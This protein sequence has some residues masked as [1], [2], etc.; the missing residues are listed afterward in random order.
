MAPTTRSRKSSAPFL[1]EDTKPATSSYHLQD[2][3]AGHRADLEKIWASDNRTP[4]LVSR[5]AW[6]EARSVDPSYVNSWFTRKKAQVLRKGLSVSPGSY[7]LAVCAPSA[8]VSSRKRNPNPRAVKRER[9]RSPLPSD[10]LKKRRKRASSPTGQRIK[11]ASPSKSTYNHSCLVRHTRAHEANPHPAC[12]TCF[13]MQHIITASTPA[14]AKPF[15]YFSFPSSPASSP[16][17][18]FS[19]EAPSSDFDIDIPLTPR[20]TQR[21][22][23][24]SI[25][26]S[27][28]PSGHSSDVRYCIYQN[29]CSS[30]AQVRNMSA[31][32]PVESPVHINSTTSMVHTVSVNSQSLLDDMIDS[33]PVLPPRQKR[34][35]MLSTTGTYRASCHDTGSIVLSVAAASSLPEGLFRDSTTEFCNNKQ[36]LNSPKNVVSSSVMLHFAPQ[37]AE[38]KNHPMASRPASSGS[39]TRNTREHEFQQE[40]ASPCN[41]VPHRPTTFSAGHP[42]VGTRN[43]LALSVDNVV[44]HNVENLVPKS[45]LHYAVPEYDSPS[46]SADSPDLSSEHCIYAT[47]TRTGNGKAL[48][49]VNPMGPT[50]A[51]PIHLKTAV[52][53]EVFTGLAR[54][55]PTHHASKTMLALLM[56][57]SELTPAASSI[58]SFSAL[59]VFVA[60]PAH[61]L[62][63][64]YGALNK[65]ALYVHQSDSPCDVAGDLSSPMKQYSSPV[66]CSEW[67]VSKPTPLL[68]HPQEIAIGNNTH[69]GSNIADHD[70]QISIRRK[71]AIS[72]LL[73][74]DDVNTGVSA[75]V[76]HSVLVLVRDYR[77]VVCQASNDSLQGSVASRSTGPADGAK[78]VVS[79]AVIEPEDSKLDNDGQNEVIQRRGYISLKPTAAV[80]KP[81][82]P[83]KNKKPKQT[84]K[85]EGKD[86]STKNVVTEPISK[87]KRKTQCKTTSAADIIDPPSVSSKRLGDIMYTAQQGHKETTYSEA[88]SVDLHSSHAAMKASTSAH[89]VQGKTA[90]SDR[91]LRQ[92][93]DAT[94][95]LECQL[96]HI[97]DAGNFAA[98]VDGNGENVL[99]IRAS[100]KAPAKAPQKRKP[101]PETTQASIKGAEKTRAGKAP[102]KRSAKKNEGQATAKT[103]ARQKNRKEKTEKE[104]KP[105]NT[106]SE[107]LLSSSLP[108]AEPLLAAPV[109]METFGQPTSSSHISRVEDCQTQE[110]QPWLDLAP[111]RST[112]AHVGD[113]QVETLLHL[114]ADMSL[115]P[116]IREL[117]G[118]PEQVDTAWLAE[119]ERLNRELGLV[120]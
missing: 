87:R 93:H 95:K 24:C 103:T 16:A 79:Q 8:S 72:S 44:H 105:G 49:F 7:E 32:M 56:N 9:S 85:P 71:M 94:I 110:H 69:D 67:L 108:T 113:Q 45:G 120:L 66:G 78:E 75:S 111:Q 70:A 86:K 5:R 61:L 15:S 63:S 4:S 117:L 60:A 55:A 54:R 19:S 82:S 96:G 62:D 40:P 3:S 43:N 46:T 26:S 39:P 106:L 116:E 92:Y 88:L 50:V 38:D 90:G 17:L 77:H 14:V 114:Y 81:T 109:R 11:H 52:G 65:S 100:T 30:K 57:S 84:E 29:S 33:G 112:P 101:K 22:G 91:S 2:L 73:V 28:P 53:T 59:P 99:P 42:D 104:K 21:V 31:Y 118:V 64:D 12:L 89:A 115:T 107:S 119:S 48:N 68:P 37:V 35:A 74:D 36:S 51:S 98:R 80:V 47:S 102:I 76:F 23:D 13:P 1:Q 10:V 41:F 34:K 20:D 6:A 97:P 18:G 58:S 83:P 25:P 27:S